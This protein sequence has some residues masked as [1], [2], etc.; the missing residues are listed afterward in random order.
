MSPIM[1]QIIRWFV[2]SFTSHKPP[3]IPYHTNMK[4]DYHH[5]EYRPYRERIRNW[6]I[7]NTFVWLP[8][9]RSMSIYSIYTQGPQ[10]TPFQ[11]ISMEFGW[12]HHFCCCCWH[13]FCWKLWSHHN[14][15]PHWSKEMFLWR[16]KEK[17]GHVGERNVN[18]N[19]SIIMLVHRLRRGYSNREMS[20]EFDNT[21][22]WYGMG[23]WR[24]V[25]CVRGP[26]LG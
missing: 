2:C 10:N 23:E 21:Y 20:F 9:I 1:Y 25:L 14:H 7:H 17:N 3:H 22:I 19:I 15:H 16:V 12:I 26:R 4:R 13:M 18:T 5:C 8:F 6:P 24:A 11:P